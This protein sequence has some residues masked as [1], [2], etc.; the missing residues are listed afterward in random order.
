VTNSKKVTVG[1]IPT[2]SIGRFVP[3]ID[4]IFNY[5]WLGFESYLTGRYL[6]TTEHTAVNDKAGNPYLETVSGWKAVN[7]ATFSVTPN[8]QHLAVTIAYTNGFSAPSYQRANGIKIG[9]LVK[10]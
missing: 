5:R 8:D 4:G 7:V 2:Y 3:Q 6:L 1:T 9:L 10:Y